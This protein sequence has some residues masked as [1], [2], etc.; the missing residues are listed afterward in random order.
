MG[1]TIHTHRASSLLGKGML[2]VAGFCLA[3]LVQAQVAPISAAWIV[4]VDT[5]LND[6]AFGDIDAE[7][8]LATLK[9]YGGALQ[10]KSAELALTRK[11]RRSRALAM[12]EAFRAM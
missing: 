7:T 3:G 10:A 9:H 5:V 1:Q 8:V 12:P 2:L 11:L 4:A 6:E